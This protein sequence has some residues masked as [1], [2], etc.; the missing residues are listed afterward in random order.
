MTVH[1]VVVVVAPVVSAAADD[2]DGD[3]DN[4]SG[5]T[6]GVVVDGEKANEDEIWHH[7]NTIQHSME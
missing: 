4:W 5:G 6:D 3:E 1:V 7:D 2:E